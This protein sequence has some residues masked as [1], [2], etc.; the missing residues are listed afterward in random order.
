[1]GKTEG[2]KRSRNSKTDQKLKIPPFL[3]QTFFNAR[4]GYI[5][6]IERYFDS[7]I[8]GFPSSPSFYFVSCVPSNAP[9]D[10]HDSSL[11]NVR[12]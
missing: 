2:I 7:L 9:L 5:A 11:K 3:F 12:R 1:M 8:L 6:K 4:R 10:A